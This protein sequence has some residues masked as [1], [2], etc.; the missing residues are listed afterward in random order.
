M[1][2]FHF[3]VELRICCTARMKIGVQL[4]EQKYLIVQVLIN[5]FR[6][7]PYA[8]QRIQSPVSE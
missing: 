5:K 4:V 7:K 1:F 6:H 3:I 8:S 2:V